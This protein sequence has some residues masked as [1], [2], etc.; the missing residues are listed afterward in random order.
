M[1]LIRAV[2]SGQDVRALKS[3]RFERLKGGRGH[4]HSIRLSG[5]WRRHLGFRDQ[6]PSRVAVAVRVED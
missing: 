1:Q 6:A 3:L 2:Q 5:R 4:Q